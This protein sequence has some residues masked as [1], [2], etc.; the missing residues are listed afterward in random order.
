MKRLLFVAGLLVSLGQAFAQQQITTVILVRHA[1]KATDGTKDPDLTEAGKVRAIA[2]VKLLN[3]VKIDAI[4]STT[5]KRTQN[6]VA[7]LAMDK[8]ITIESY[9]AMKGE[10][11]DE[12]IKKFPGGTVVICGHSNTT[13]WTANY[14]LGKEQYKD[15]D[16]SDYDNV[17]LLNVVQKGN[18]K[19]TWL[20]Y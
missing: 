18:A 5:F 7:Q 2:L 8:G 4:Y 11:I 16:D 20:T 19:A 13:P 9:N 15:F 1:E 10:A 14:L 17:L 6:T 12:I 3:E